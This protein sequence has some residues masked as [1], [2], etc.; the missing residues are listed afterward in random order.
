MR[1]LSLSLLFF[2]VLAFSSI[3]QSCQ[4]AE[5]SVDVNQDKIHQYLELQYNAFEDK[6]TAVAQFRFG[7]AIG[8]PLKLTGNAA[9]TADGNVMTWNEMLNRYEWTWTGET[10]NTTFSYTDNDL[11]TFVNSIE[12]REIAIPASL[13]TISQ[14]SSYNLVWSG[15]ALDTNEEVQAIVNEQGEVN[16]TIFDQKNVG[17]TSITLTK[18]RLATV[19]PGVVS[20]WLN[21]DY[22]PAIVQATDAGGII[23]GKYLD[24]KQNVTLKN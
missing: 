1:I 22:K 2:V 11:N 4:E 15:N 6:T 16:G 23:V 13:D 7:N 3:T 14:D 21:R 12:V 24:I 5:D 9:I 18:N 20:V 17:A 10:S 19:D 8:T